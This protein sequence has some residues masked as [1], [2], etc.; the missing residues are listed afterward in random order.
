MRK[1]KLV[2]WIFVLY[3]LQNIILPIL[4]GSAVVP[5][6][7]L[8]FAVSYTV[9]ECKFSNTSAVIVITSLLTATGTGRV[10]SLVSVLAGLAAITAYFI[11]DY[12]RFIPQ[13]VRTQAVIAVFAFIMCIS[14]YFIYSKTMSAGFILNT[15][16]PYTV[17]TIAASCVIYLILKRTMF[18]ANDKKL[19]TA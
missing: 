17:Y 1:L 3:L 2:L 15:A 5:E 12:V 16:L 13:F 11:K 18:K 4:S 9:L 7:L 6:L 19:L 14:E 8:G 10:F